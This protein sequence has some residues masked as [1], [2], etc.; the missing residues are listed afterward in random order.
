[1]EFNEI[2]NDLEID[3]NEPA[4]SDPTDASHGSQ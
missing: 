1:M 3:I 2:L 4:T